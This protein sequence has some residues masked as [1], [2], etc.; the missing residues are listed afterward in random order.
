MAPVQSKMARAATEL[1]IEDVAEMAQVAAGTIVRFE[2]GEELKP[3]T[4]EAIQ[5]AFEEAGVEFINDDA[6]GVKLHAR[7]EPAKKK[8]KK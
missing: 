2:R 7:V 1:R 6:P 8:K 4:V 5:R 3:R